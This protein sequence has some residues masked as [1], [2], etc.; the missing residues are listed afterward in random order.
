[1]CSF[2]CITKL[3]SFCWSCYLLLKCRNNSKWFSYMYLQFH[4]NMALLQIFILRPVLIRG[5]SE[6]S[7]TV[8]VVTAPVK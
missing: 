8:I 1:M 5:V 6:S 3:I 2:N 4:D 7:R